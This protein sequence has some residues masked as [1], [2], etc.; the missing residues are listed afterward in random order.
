MDSE[1]APVTAAGD[2]PCAELTWKI[3]GCAM[4]VLNYYGP[5]YVEY[6]YQKA[7]EHVF[8]KE[9]IP[10]VAKTELPIFFEGEAIGATL[11]P[12]FLVDD[13]VIV[14]IKSLAKLTQKNRKQILS[15]MKAAN[16]EVGLLI[17][18]GQSRLE[19]ERFVNSPAAK[20]ESEK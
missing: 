12:D 18:F 3:I 11:M 14:E 4:K 15:Y 20:K 1:D 17:N 9:N 5:W 19:W 13:T 2:F 10:F 6:V 7:L 16:K 8:K